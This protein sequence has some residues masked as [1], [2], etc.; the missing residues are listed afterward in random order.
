MKGD[1]ERGVYYKGHG[2][3]VTGGEDRRFTMD[4][5]IDLS[6]RLSIELTYSVLNLVRQVGFIWVIGGRESL[7]AIRVRWGSTRSG[8]MR[9]ASIIP[10]I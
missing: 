3:Q 1:I 4:V 7:K 5:F 6:K 2:C 8:G 9:G 10:E